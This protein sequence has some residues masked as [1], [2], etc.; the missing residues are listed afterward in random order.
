MHVLK[1]PSQT[2][3]FHK[4]SLFNAMRQRKPP[5]SSKPTLLLRFSRQHHEKHLKEHLSNEKDLRD[6]HIEHVEARADESGWEGVREGEWC[7][8]GL[9]GDSKRPHVDSFWLVFFSVCSWHWSRVHEG[10][11]SFRLR[12]NHLGIWRVGGFH[13]ARVSW[14]WCPQAVIRQE[15]EARDQHHQHHTA[16]RLRRSACWDGWDRSVC[17]YVLAKRKHL[18]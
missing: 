13:A 3:Q 5:I 14:P 4:P 10:V 2:P 15:K 17:W 8:D 16:G 6:R 11:G 18:R 12:M 1:K 7:H 9:H